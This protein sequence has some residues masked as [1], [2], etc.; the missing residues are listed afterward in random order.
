M[1][2]QRKLLI[3]MADAPGSGKSTLANLLAQSLNGVVIDHDLIRSF[4]LSTSIPFSL[5][6]QLSYSFQWVLASDILKQGRSV[7]VDSTC[8]YDE[9]LN[10]GMALANLYGVEYKYVEC[11][12]EVVE[13]LDQRLRGRAPMRSQRSGVCLPLPDAD[14][15]GGGSNEDCYK[16][17]ERWI[18]HPCR[19][20]SDAIIVDSAASPE[21]CL[22]SVLKQI[23]SSAGGQSAECVASNFLDS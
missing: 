15:E 18:E 9:T 23:L 3:Q 6:A 10:Q 20:E 7:I 14:A 21:K 2:P 22:D 11:R 17:F 19:P 16:L 4:F 8:N 12:V 1:D 13:L 5:S